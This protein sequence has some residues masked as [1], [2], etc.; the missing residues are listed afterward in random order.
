MAGSA[1]DDA[2]RAPLWEAGYDRSHP[3]YTYIRTLGW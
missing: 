2:N 3:M 1:A